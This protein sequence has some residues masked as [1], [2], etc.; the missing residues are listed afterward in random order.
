[1]FGD[2][3][4]DVEQHKEMPGTNVLAISWVDSVLELVE[5]YKRRVEGTIEL[6]CGNLCATFVILIGSLLFLGVFIANFAAIIDFLLTTT[7]VAN[8]SLECFHTVPNCE[9][10]EVV[11][12]LTNSSTP[13]DDQYT[14]RFKLSTS[15]IVYFQRERIRR[16]DDDCGFSDLFSATNGTFKAGPV[17]CFSVKERFK[18]YVHWFSCAPVFRRNNG[19]VEEKDCNAILVPTS[20]YDPSFATGMAVCEIAFFLMLSRCVWLLLRNVR[21]E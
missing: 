18:R 10:V 7:T 4:E 21:E 20:D 15:P 13:C 8:N 11:H 6:I 5:E 19:T 17:R 2:E 14:Y 12:K 3:S 16:A 9:V 1:M